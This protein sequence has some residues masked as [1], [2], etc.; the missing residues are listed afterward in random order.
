MALTSSF[1]KIEDLFFDVGGSEMADMQYSFKKKLMAW[2]LS[3][4]LVV[5]LIPEF[6]FAVTADNNDEI[7]SPEEVTMEDIVEKTETVT[8]YDIGGGE[9]MSVLHGGQVRFEDERGRLVDYDPSLKPVKPEED[10]LQN[11]PLKGYLYTNKIGDKKHYLPETISEDI[12]VRMEYKDYAIEFALTDETAEQL[13]I[14]SDEAVVEETTVQTP[15]EDEAELPVNAVYGDEN[16]DTKLTYTSTEDSVK[17]TLVLNEVPESNVFQYRLNL[18]GMYARKNITDNGITYYDKETEEITGYISAPWMNDAGGQ[19]YSEEITYDIEEVEGSEGEYLLTMTVDEAYLNDP[20]RQY[21]VTIDPTNTWQGSSEVIDVYVISGSTYGNTNFYE[22]GTKKMPSG[23]NSTGTHRTYIKFIDLKGITSGK[24]VTSAKFTAYQTTDCVGSQSIGIYRV[25][26]NWTTSKLTYNNR[27][28][29]STCYDTITTT[30]TDYAAKTWNVTTFVRN[31][32]DDKISNYGLQL[33]NK[34]SSPSFGCFYGSRASSYKPKMVVTYYSKPTALSSASLSKSTSSGYV[35]TS[36]FAKGKGVYATWK[37]ISSSILSQ[38]QYK[39][40]AYDSNTSSPTSISDDKVNLTTYRSI[41][42]AASSGTNKYVSYSKYLPAGKYKLYLRGKDSNGYVGGAKYL[43]FYVD[44]TKPTLTGVSITPSTSTSSYTRTLTPTVKWTAKD[45]YFSKVVISLNGTALKTITTSGSGSYTIPSGKITTTGTKKIKVTAYDKAGNST[46]VEKSYYADRTVPTIGSISLKDNSGVSIGSNYTKDADPT[47]TFS[48]VTD[49]LNITTS[50]LSYAIRKTGATTTLSYKTPTDINI[51]SA[52]PYSGSFTLN[53]A[54]E[55]LATGEYTIYVRATD[56]A[57][58]VSAVKSISYKKDIS[59]PTGSIKVTEQGTATEVTTLKNTSNIVISASG[60]GS[61]LKLVQLKLYKVSTDETETECFDFGSGSATGNYDLNTLNYPNGDYRLKLYLEDTV[62]NT[63][64]VTKDVVIANPLD[65]P[66]LITEP[67]NNGT[68][69]ISWDIE[70]ITKVAKFQYKVGETETWSDVDI[71]T[72]ENTGSFNVTLPEE[73]GEYDIHVRAID[74]DGLVGKSTEISCVLDKTE[75]TVELTGFENGYLMGNI[76]DENAVEW[77]LAV[78]ESNEEDTEYEEL[79]TDTVKISDGKIAFVDFNDDKYIAGKT[80]DF[81]LIVK[82]VAGNIK[83]SVYS[84]EKSDSDL[85]TSITAAGITIKKSENQNNASNKLIYPSNITK[86]DLTDP[87]NIN[88]TVTWYVDNAEKAISVAYQC[89]FSTDSEDSVYEEYTE[90]PI[91]VINKK[92]DGTRS[93]SR[94]IL[95]NV[96]E[97]ITFESDSLEDEIELNGNK[98][99]SFRIVDPDSENI[100]SVK[101]GDKEFKTVAAGETI[102]ISDLFEGIAYAEDLIVKSSAHSSDVSIQIDILEADNIETFEL[103]NIENYRPNHL[104]TTDKINYKTY[105]QWENKIAEGTP[106]NI[107]Y[108][109]YRGTTSGFTPGPETLAATG[110]R[111]GYYS[112][113]NVNFSGNFYYKVRAVE[114]TADGTYASSFS[115]ERFGRVVDSDEYT[116]RMGVKEYW[117][118]ADIETPNGDISIEKSMGNMVYQ[119]TD[120]M[121]PNEGLEVELTRTYNSQS[122]SKSAFGVGWSHDYDIELLRICK[123]DDINDANLVMKD[124]SGTIYH[125][126][127]NEDGIY[128][129]SLGKYITLKKEEL[130]EDVKIPARIIGVADSGDEKATITINSSYTIDTKDNIQYR[131]NSGGQLI[132]MEEANGNFMIFE[133]EPDK[134]LIQRAVTSKNLAMEF[135]YNTEDNTDKLTVKEVKLPNGTSLLYEYKGNPAKELVRLVKV[136]EKTG[137]GETVSYEY[138]YDDSGIP[139]VKN[140]SDAL[141]NKYSIEYNNKDQ[142]EAVTYPDGDKITLEYDANVDKALAVTAEQVADIENL[143]IGITTVTSKVTKGDVVSKETDTF[144]GFGN[145]IS[146]IDAEGYKTVYDYE[147]NNHLLSKTTTQTDSYYIDSEGYVKQAEKQNREETTNYE[148]D[149]ENETIEVEEDGTKTEY[150]YDENAN[151]YSDDLPVTEKETTKDENGNTVEVFDLS[152]EYDEFGNETKEYDAVS[153]TTTVTEYYYSD[154]ETGLRGEIKKETEYLGGEEEANIQSITEYSY[155]YAD[156]GSK[157]EEVKQT[158]GDDVITITTVYDSM[159]NEISSDDDRGKS[160]K[161]TYDGFGRLIHT[162]YIDGDIVTNVSKEYNNNGMVT[163]ETAED[164]TITSY[165]YD[166]MNRIESRTVTKG[167]FTKTWTIDYG[168]EDIKI[169]DGSGEP[170]EIKNAFYTEETNPDNKVISTIYQDH[171]GRTVKQFENGIYVD[172]T[173]DGQGNVLTQ[174]EYAK[175]QNVSDGLLTM[176]IYNSAGNLTDTVLSPEYVEG[177]G[178]YTGGAAIVTSSEYD[179]SGNEIATIDGEGFRTEFSYDVEGNITSVKLPNGETTTYQYDVVNEDGTTSNFTID[180][181]GNKSEVVSDKGAL[182]ILVQDLGDGTV[183]PIKTTLEYNAKE[184]VT[185]ETDSEGNYRTYEYD[186]RDRMTVSNY[187]DTSDNKTLKTTYAYDI[188]DNLIETKDYKVSGETEVLVRI[189]KY[190]YDELKRL[191]GYAELDGPAEPTEDEIAAAT[192]TYH[193]DINDNLIKVEYPDTGSKIEGLNFTYNDYNWIE[194]IT[195]DTGGLVKKDVRDYAYS[196]D[197]KIHKIKDYR[198]ILNGGNE[199]IEREYSYDEFERVI[200]ITYR[201]SSDPDVVK[202]SY[203]YTYD[204]N[205]NIISEEIFNNYPAADADKVH[206]IRTHEYNDI[207]QLILTQV[208]DKLG[209][210]GSNATIY[211]YSY[212][213]VGNRTKETKETGLSVTELEDVNNGEEDINEEDTTTEGE[214][215]T[216]DTAF[217]L[218]FVAVAEADTIE[219]ETE[220]GTAVENQITTTTYT[221]NS[222]NQI[223]SSSEDTEGVNTSAISYTYDKNGNQ[224]TEIDSITGESRTMTYDAAGNM[225][226]LVAKNGDTITLTQENVYNGEGQ[227]IRKTEADNTI[228]YYYQGANVLYTTDGTGALSAQNLIGISENTIATTR[229][230]G[231]SESYYVYNKDIREST[232]NLVNSAGNSEVSYEYTDYGE[233]EITGNKDFYNEIC[234]TGGIYDAST[235]IYYLNARYYDPEN[236]SFLSQDS[237]RGEVG[238]PESLNLYSYCYGNPIVYTDPSGHIPV[239]VVVAVKV[240]GRI[241]L[242]QVAKKAAKKVIKKTIKKGIKKTAGK[243]FKAVKQT[244]KLKK[245]TVKPKTSK[246][247]LK[248]TKKTYKKSRLKAS[249]KKSVKKKVSQKRSNEQLVKNVATRAERKV[250]ASGR[251]AGTNKHKY[252]KDLLDRYQKIYG[253]RGLGT[254]RS[255]IGGNKVP[256]GTKGSARVD[257]LD[258]KNKVAYDYKFTKRPGKGLSKKQIERIKGSV[259]KSNRI[260]INNVLEVNP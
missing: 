151:E 165:T 9:K 206:E 166:E 236:A 108:E 152:Y 193:Y 189:T 69:V 220:E 207:G 244:K 161:N 57:G 35:S 229:G 85:F 181:K 139:N 202:E 26:E 110:I 148:E 76:S 74:I 64:T 222:L 173:Y 104:T 141:G 124:G 24:S 237:Y 215:S 217:V 47:V 101:T 19:A 230:T 254:E 14:A 91:F 221:Y 200:G 123:D 144:N 16:D 82:D 5:T 179:P 77:Y 88:G 1:I 155:T 197:G 39:I 80:Y 174:Y 240:G 54:D 46:Y 134:G 113:I 214:D 132:Y 61:D 3:I 234:Y 98:V 102:Y 241:I 38:V 238:N 73:D 41:G 119:Q 235:G 45:T 257:V 34:S 115:E 167:G 68:A 89:D 62:G 71:D 194:K 83:N 78:K 53:S 162:E 251:V 133:Y 170:T 208:E 52:K 117:E 66:Q 178:Y 185:R 204:K 149:T 70:D 15:Y 156:D 219:D 23:K 242:K 28:T 218:P 145:C 153:D 56:K 79:K 95:C 128:T 32:A 256:Y 55:G 146:S 48:N 248:S 4:S 130:S 29:S 87:E 131:F 36:Y 154:S 192:I 49:N 232:T 10:T 212:D 172:M 121:L 147:K 143:N 63:N 164:G 203:T 96:I 157:T 199:Y 122:S 138:D 159:G 99:V 59:K 8:T 42:L 190:T 11:M 158:C 249:S 163:K 171:L 239:L 175:E 81:R 43:T 65:A 118:Y 210:P 186:G 129:S 160:T 226:R 112:E 30:S 252:A 233:T 198:D 17:E 231:D 60:T 86:I 21:P 109:V 224:L 44:G 136:T 72:E 18:T 84:I 195:A 250:G 135:V 51:N 97:P 176:F 246:K 90:Y 213:A 253:D 6:T 150:G 196:D 227:R 20:S 255:Y 40:T 260:R 100:F 137:S 103:S 247:Y 205:N 106:E 243:S 94:D 37:G 2:I 25:T 182:D 169:Y 211:E 27:P 259:N 183:D 31:L 7:L 216:T 67:T 120:A 225:S 142:V 92:D 188:S 93:Y 12:P 13:S 75:P 223:V 228:N 168:Y 184:N 177:K 180:A 187:Y 107:Y 114:E 140:I 111:A 58:N 245:V 22:S 209:D 201:D 258:I 191:T 126:V 105:I 125:F 50:C 127:K 116:K 33:Y